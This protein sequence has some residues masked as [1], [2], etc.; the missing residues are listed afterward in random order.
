MVYESRLSLSILASLSK[1]ERSGEDSIYNQKGTIPIPRNAFRSV[2][3]TSNVPKANEQNLE[4]IHWQICGSL[5]GQCNY[6]LKIKGRA[7]YQTIEILRKLRM[8][9]YHLTQ[10]N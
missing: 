5:F 4:A 8:P 9:K 1:K 10:L 2:Q 3:C 6:P 7:Y